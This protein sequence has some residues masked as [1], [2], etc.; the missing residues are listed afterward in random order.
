[1]HFNYAVSVT[2]L[3]LNRR[4]LCFVTKTGGDFAKKADEFV[5]ALAYTQ[6]IIHNVSMHMG[7]DCCRLTGDLN[8]EKSV[9]QNQTTDFSLSSVQ[10][11]V[12]HSCHLGAQP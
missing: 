8:L 4:K 3:C 5:Q 6:L 9:K 12:G 2:S 11:M 1:M 7:S 10:S